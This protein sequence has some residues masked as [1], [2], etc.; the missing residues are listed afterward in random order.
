VTDPVVTGTSGSAGADDPPGDR[1]VTE[2]SGADPT[3]PCCE[4]GAYGSGYYK[5]QWE[6]RWDIDVTKATSLIPARTFTGV[7]GS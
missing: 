6:D 3:P 7:I 4:H 1:S 2:K 5:I